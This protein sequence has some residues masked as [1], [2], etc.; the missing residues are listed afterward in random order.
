MMRNYSLAI[1]L[2]FINILF[3][4]GQSN[5]LYNYEQIGTN[6]YKIDIG[7]KSIVAS[8]GNN[9]VLLC[10]VGNENE[11]DY[12]RKAIKELD[13]RKIN[14][15]V[16][17]HW[18]EDHCGGNKSFG[19][20]AVIIAHENVRKTL[21]KDTYLKFWN[22]EHPAYPNYALPDIVFNYKMN[23]YFNDEDI[24][25]IHLPNGHTDGDVIVFFQKSNILYV[26]D[27]I[28]SNGF[29]AIDFET[30]GSAEG[31]ANNLKTIV[32]IM[33]PDVKIVVGHG[34][35]FRIQD[36]QT[37]E[38]MIRS[39]LNT[40]RT[41]MQNGVTI[42]EIKNTNLLNE[43]KDYGNGFFSCDD[44]IEILYHSLIKIDKDEKSNI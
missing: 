44:W 17:T 33:P 23:L 10:D 8:V 30:G 9:G 28:F 19:I 34:P 16:D 5:V 29:P 26:G 37:Y 25:I 24:A 32:R 14:Y 1:F 41:A 18:H 36:V 40:I 21:S 13:G 31:F 2:M 42:K 35:D 15:I 12:I 20:E 4:Q 3:I 11:S 7:N 39:S 22:E 38:K 6:L 43:W 27:C